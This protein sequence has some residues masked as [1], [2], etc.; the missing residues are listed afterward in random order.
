MP[1]L[2]SR[3]RSNQIPLLEMLVHRGHGSLCV[4][5]AHTRRG[6]PNAFTIETAK[7]LNKAL[8]RST[9]KNG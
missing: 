1:R 2:F 6:E 8:V 4:K 3:L 9:T 5:P 7:L